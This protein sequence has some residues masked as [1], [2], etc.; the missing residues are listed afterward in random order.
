MKKINLGTFA[1][2]TVGKEVV[3]IATIN[4]YVPIKPTNSKEI[5]CTICKGTNHYAPYMFARNNISRVWVCGN[6]QCDTMKME[7]IPKTI[8]NQ[9]T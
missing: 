2:E 4:R 8:P 3:Y 6:A 5:C 7:N 9:P 1:Y